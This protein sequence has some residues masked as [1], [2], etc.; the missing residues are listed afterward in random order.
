MLNS[1]MFFPTWISFQTNQSDCGCLTDATRYTIAGFT[2]SQA[3]IYYLTNTTVT[4]STCGVGLSLRVYVNNRLVKL[5]SVP[6]EGTITFNTVLGTLA[7]GDVVYVAVAAAGLGSCAPSFVWDFA[8]QLFSSSNTAAAMAAASVTDSN[9]LVA[10]G[11][12]YCEPADV[13]VV[14]SYQGQLQVCPLRPPLCLTAC[15]VCLSV[16]LV[17]LSVCLSVCP[18]V[19]IPRLAL[20]HI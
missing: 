6:A 4:A 17:C 7:T 11:Q 13:G 3:G 10:T 5:A 12:R 9:T 18:S 20:S 8:L 16:C 1:M 2:V 19:C 14:Y 15:P